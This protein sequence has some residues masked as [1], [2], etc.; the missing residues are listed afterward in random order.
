MIGERGPFAGLSRNTVLLALASLF[1]DI[2]A[3]MLYPVVPIFL[4]QTLRAGGGAVGLIEGVAVATRN[5]AMGISGQVSDRLARRKP[6]ALVGYAL[7]AVAKPMTGLA[8]GWPA[9]LGA[10]FADRLGS[11][12]RTAPRDALVAA[13]ADP[14]HQGKAFGL[15]GAGDNAGAFIGP[16]LAVAL[17]SLAAAPLRWIFFLSAVPGII[18]F[19]LVVL[20]KEPSVATPP[21][22]TLDVAPARF[23]LAWRRYLL[24]TALFGLGKSGNAFLILRANE[25][26]LSL[27]D[28][29]L[30]YAGYNLLAAL[31]SYPAGA[32]SDR[33][34]RRNLVIAALCI[35]AVS[36]CGFAL[37]R[38]PL[39]VSALFVLLGAHQGVYRTA[40]KA[41]ASDLSPPALRAGGIGWFSAVGGLCALVA[42]L[43]AGQLWDHHLRGVVFVIGAVGAAAGAAA[44][45]LLVGAREVAEA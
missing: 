18:A 42:A 6:I 16:L 27:I 19:C 25:L 17:I 31:I 22:A 9:V 7:A 21:K 35:F 3:E 44:L 24:A 40:G 34:G 1:S 14:A 41:L 13:S 15:E 23:S 12:V 30:V 10:R 26:G 8:V 39:V 2:A 38:S 28:T 5:L 29:I 11:G 32:L 20:V 33:F 43:V 45:A 37:S 4:T 36:Y